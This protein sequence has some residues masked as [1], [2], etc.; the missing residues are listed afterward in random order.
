[1]RKTT[2]PLMNKTFSCCITLLLTTGF[3]VLLLAPNAF[4]SSDPH[5]I[6]RNGK[7]YADLRHR[8][9]HVDQSGFRKMRQLLP[10]DHA[11]AYSQV[12]TKASKHRLSSIQSAPLEPAVTTVPLTV[13]LSF[14][15]LLTLSSTN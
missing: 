9:E 3:L 5:D 15:L 8:Y 11:L 4:A 7:F 12:N 10:F 6:I 13:K 14:L 1:M 2:L